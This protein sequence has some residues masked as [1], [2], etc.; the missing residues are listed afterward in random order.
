MTRPYSSLLCW[1]ALAIGASLILYHTSDRVTSLGHQ[2]NGLN[3]QIEAEQQSLHVL[4]AEWVYLANP[5]RVEAATLRH[6]DLQPTAPARVV[7]MKDIS[8]LLPLRA[9]VEPAPQ[10]VAEKSLPPSASTAVAS[11][12]PPPASVGP[13]VAAPSFVAAHLAAL[14]GA[15]IKTGR[16]VAALGGGLSGSL[17]GGHINERMIMPHVAA[18]E[19]SNDGIG[20]LI[21][22]LSLRP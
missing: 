13:S 8:T 14:R 18:V 21:S 4:Q 22:S 16:V 3:E 6:L 10:A 11:A 7:A 15:Q 9:G 17:G 5:A 12:A 19:A 1:F 20:A 2:L